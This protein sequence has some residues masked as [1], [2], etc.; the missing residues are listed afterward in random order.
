MFICLK[1]LLFFVTLFRDLPSLFT[2][3]SDL[4][5]DA[6]GAYCFVM[7]RILGR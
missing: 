5:G 6:D 4:L 7:V 1:S 2:T 3:S